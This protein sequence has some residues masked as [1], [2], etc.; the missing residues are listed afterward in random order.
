MDPVES[1]AEFQFH[2]EAVASLVAH[3][4][5]SLPDPGNG[6]PPCCAA[7]CAPCNTLKRLQARGLLSDWVRPYIITS[8][9]DPDEP[10]CDW[11]QG[12]ARHGGVRWDWVTARVC[13]SPAA[14]SAPAQ[15][16]LS[17][18]GFDDAG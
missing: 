14:C 18:D 3:A 16:L 17:L 10:G 4:L 7:E 6:D 2:R 1:E 12:S 11:W 13:V 9:A 5:N 8:S 15:C